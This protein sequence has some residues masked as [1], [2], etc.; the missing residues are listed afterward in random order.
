MASLEILDKVIIKRVGPDSYRGKIRNGKVYLDRDLINHEVAIMKREYFENM[1]LS[2]HRLEL[3]KEFVQ[4]IFNLNNGSKMFNI[5]SQTW[6]PVTG[7]LHHCVYCWARKIALTRLRHSRRYR[8]G[9]IPRLNEEEFKKKFNGGVV[10]VSDMGDLFGEFIPREWILRVIEYIKRFPNTYF[11][12]LTK[13]PKRYHEFIH[14]FPD[15]A[16]L[17]ATIETNR[18]SYYIEKRISSAPIPSNRYLAMKELEWELKFISI[19]P[20][21]DFDMD[22]FIKW[23]KDIDPFMVYVGYD[24]YGWKL[25]EP[26]LTKTQELIKRLSEFTLVIKKTIRPAW[27]EKILK[28]A[29]EK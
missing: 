3:I 23:I 29:I 18:D 2:L 15:N 5:I 1:I 6:N 28:Y 22:I 26:P 4:Y 8:S 19:E 11:L 13:N 24:N 10:F 12:F 25:P 21:L 17:G 9:F 14:L 27:N 16:I 7:C 20:I